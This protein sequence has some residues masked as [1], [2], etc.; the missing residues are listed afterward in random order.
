MRSN[1]KNN[2]QLIVLAL[3][4]LALIAFY[5]FYGLNFKIL[6]YQ[7]PSRVLRTC[8]IIVVATAIA[9]STVIMQT[10]VK[11]RM[12]TPTIM[13][14]E[15]VYVFIQTPI[16]FIAGVSSPLLLNSAYHYF[17]SMTILVI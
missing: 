17:L 6:H 15:S 5:M 1:K 12:I 13:G 9:G 3:I 4:A 16:V 14:L 10:I 8:A 11:N 7:L 2:I